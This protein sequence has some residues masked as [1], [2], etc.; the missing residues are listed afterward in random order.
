MDLFSLSNDPPKIT[1]WISAATSIIGVPFVIYSL[2]KLIKK[3]K[4]KEAQISKLASIA[5]VLEGQTEA[6]LKQ[7]ELIAQ[8][9]DIFRN[10][11][12][13]K[14][15][16]VEGVAQLR[17]IEEKR[18]RLSVRPQI[19][20]IGS[21]Y[22][23]YSGEFD[24]HLLNKGEVAYL[25]E[26]V[27][28]EG[29]VVLHSL[30]IPWEFEKGAERYIFGRSNGKLHIKDTSYKIEVFYHDA[31]NNRYQLVIEHKGTNQHAK[32]VCDEAIQ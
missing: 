27:L 4:D 12:I 32:I 25:D 21:G 6:M 23:G 1:D 31:L 15:N 13:L 22:K 14:D 20:I 19:R 5:G 8:Q 26:I 16:N 17:D 24:I 28:I 29:E 9:V 2:V 18:L 11:S 10:T 7:N 3:D 30:S